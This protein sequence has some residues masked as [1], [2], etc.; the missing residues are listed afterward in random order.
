M[1][2]LPLPAIPVAACMFAVHLLAADFWQTKPFTE[3]NDKD[4][5]K[6][7]QSSPWARPITVAMSGGPGA[8]N[9]GGLDG[10]SGLGAHKSIHP[11]DAAA[12]GAGSVVLIV[13]WQ[14]AKPVREAVIKARFGNEAGT[15]AEARKALEE[16]VDHY[17]ISIC[18][19]PST[20]FGG[21]AEEFRQ[22]MLAQGMLVIKGKD[23]IK[24]VDF[25]TEDTGHSAQGM[26]VFP[27]T[28]PITEDDKEVEFIV[29]IR[30]TSIRQ[31]FH[32]KEM[33]YN[34]KLDL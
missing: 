30:D 8:A 12:P 22:Q 24:P 3:W 34:G 4:V 28:D 23:P 20:A 15:S 16:P 31:K 13:R 11:G 29:K 27:K 19:L 2:K 21:N 14:S 26:F 17:I 5:Q 6:L 10:F 9:A 18:G 32:V 33:L 7:L 25:T 1:I